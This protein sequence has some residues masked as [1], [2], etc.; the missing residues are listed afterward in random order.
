MSNPHTTARSGDRLDEFIAAPRRAVW[1]MAIPM[2]AGMAVHSLYV[3]G[4][5]AFIG[6]LGTA[7]LAAATFIGPL[8]FIMITL[9][10]GMS[11][12]VTALVAQAVG[13][14]EVGGGDAVAGT[15]MSVGLALGVMLSIGGLLGGERTIALLGA[16][17]PTAELGWQYFQIICLLVPFFFVSSVLRAILTGEGDARTPT[18]ILAISTAINLSF[19]ALFIYGLDLGLRGAALATATAQLFSLTAFWFLVVRRRDAYVRFHLWAL[20]PN[21]KVLWQIAVLGVPT[22]AGMMVM[23]L[24]AMALNRALSEFGEAAVAGYGAANKVDMIVGMPIFGLAAATVTVV[25][26]FAGAGRAD[27]IRS[28]ALYTYRWALTMALSIGAVAYLASPWILR[29]FTDD[30]ASIE[31]GRTY[32]GF[33]IFAYPMMAVGMTSGRLLQGLGHGVPSLVITSVR[34]LLVAV[35]AAYLAVFAFGTPVEGIWASLLLGGGCATVLSILW[36]RHL[37]WKRDPTARSAEA[38]KEPRPPA[39]LEELRDNTPVVASGKS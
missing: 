22:A 6:N 30:P 2:M 39:P 34:V 3:I 35:P 13:R 9:T 20:V 38:D 31:V 15:A 32:L 36:V 19:D 14:R 10:M 27:L 18:V 11:T 26:M 29:I 8:F 12:A 5:T 17:G 4:D 37:V 7:Q 28:T 21:G 24:G 23:S 16:D 33:M 25:G 1:T